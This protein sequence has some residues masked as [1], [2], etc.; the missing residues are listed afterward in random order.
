[1]LDD[2]RE[3]LAAV[4]SLI[5]VFFFA[6]V[7]TLARTFHSEREFRRAIFFVNLPFAILCATIAGGI[8]NYLEVPYV[9]QYALAGSFAFLGQEWLRSRLRHQLGRP[10][11]DDDDDANNA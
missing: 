9:I 1:M 8:G 7:G 4:V 6:L 2:F 5:G 11:R 10:E 3:Q